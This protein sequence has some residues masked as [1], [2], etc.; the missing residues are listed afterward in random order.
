MRAA[1]GIPVSQLAFEMGNSERV[2]HA[3]YRAAVSRREAEEF[4]A[5]RPAQKTPALTS[6]VPG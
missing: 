5:L 4:W 3:H 2:I 6:Q 1:L